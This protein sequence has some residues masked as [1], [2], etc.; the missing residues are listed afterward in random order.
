MEPKMTVSE[1]AA[2][3]NFSTQAVHKRIKSKDLPIKRKQNR[4]YFGHETAKLLFDLSFPNKIIVFQNIKGGVGKTELTYCV[5]I[6]AHLYGAKILC[7]DL[8][9]QA[10]LTKGCFK[11]NPKDKPIMLDV[12]K[13]NL[14][15]EDTII[16]ILPGLDLI[17]SDLDNGVLDNTLTLGHFPLDRVLKDKIAGLKQ[18]YD[19]ILIDCPPALTASVTATALAADEIIAPVTPDEHSFAGLNLLH[20]EIQVIEKKFNRKINLKVVLNKFDAR[21][22]L[23]HD[24]LVLLKESDTFKGK[25]YKSYIRIAQD[26]PNAIDSGETIF[27]TFKSTAAKEDI[28]L[29]TKEILGIEESE[30]QYAEETV[31]T[32]IT[33]KPSVKNKQVESMSME[34]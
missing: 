33:T 23:S 17:P 26:F 9:Q 3:L 25:F 8:D 14:P 21:N 34:G 20:K 11:V 6:K 5:A 30:H 16:N 19:L 28:D 29:L 27:D 12:I 15:I 22:N 1:A 7:I 24:K 32:S 10:N 2:F 31:T 18:Q 4:F 13:E